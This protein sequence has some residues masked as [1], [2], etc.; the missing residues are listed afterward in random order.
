MIIIYPYEFLAFGLIYCSMLVSLSYA[1]ELILAFIHFLWVWDSSS[2]GLLIFLQYI[3]SSLTAQCL[4]KKSYFSGLFS[5]FDSQFIISWCP[6][7][8]IKFQP[9]F[10]ISDSNLKAVSADSK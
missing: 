1:S 2:I 5:I 4:P 10:D 7:D 9:V 6:S 3:P 8:T